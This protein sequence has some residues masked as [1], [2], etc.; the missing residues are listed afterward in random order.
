MIGVVTL[1]LFEKAKLNKIA[2]A[3]KVK[4][5]FA[6]DFKH[7]LNLANRHLSDIS[8]PTLDATGITVHDGANHADERMAVNLDAQLCVAAVDHAI[9]S[10]SYPNNIILYLSFIQKKT[11]DEIGARLGYQSTRFNEIK[12]E[13]CVEFAERIEYWR[14]TEGASLDDLRVFENEEIAN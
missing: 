12:S 7:Y 6:D 11:N 1:S 4:D 2:T 5:F 13:A 9:S 10:C 14:K 8:S 3:Q